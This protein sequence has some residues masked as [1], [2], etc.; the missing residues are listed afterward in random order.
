M[1]AET[2][3]RSSGSLTSFSISEAMISTSYGVRF[4]ASAYDRST[5]CHAR[6][7]ASS[8]RLISCRDVVFDSNWYEA[9]KR[10]PSSGRRLPSSANLP[11]M[12]ELAVAFR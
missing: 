6:S 4:L 7:K 1:T 8:W 10:K 11:G 12:R 5:C 3:A 2:S 9:G